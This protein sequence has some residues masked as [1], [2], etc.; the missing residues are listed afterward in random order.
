MEQ[1][2]DPL[3]GMPT[4]VPVIDNLPQHASWVQRVRHLCEFAVEFR[5]RV[6]LEC[7]RGDR[8]PDFLHGDAYGTISETG[9]ARS[10]KAMGVTVW[11]RRNCAVFS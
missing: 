5:R 6:V 4:V 7:S 11:P 1:R 10:G 3:V 2:A 8:A 9:T